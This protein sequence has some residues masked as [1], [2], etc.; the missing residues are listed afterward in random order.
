[1]RRVFL[2]YR[3]IDTATVSSMLHKSLE[4]PNAFGPQSTF[5]DIR[6][7]QLGADFRPSISR[8]VSQCEFFLAVIGPQWLTVRESDG[9]PRLQQPDDYV[10][11]EI[12]AALER[13]TEILII[14][15]LVDGA[16][17]P[18]ADQLPKSLCD[19]SFRNAM[20]I[21][22]EDF[23][24]D[25]LR[26]VERMQEL[27]EP[28]QARSGANQVPTV[29]AAPVT[30]SA[31][32]KPLP[33]SATAGVPA[34]PKPAATTSKPPAIVSKPAATPSKSPAKAKPPAAKSP[35]AS[36]AATVPPAAP[37]PAAKPVKAAPTPTPPKSAAQAPVATPKS[38]APPLSEEVIPLVLAQPSPPANGVRMP[39][40]RITIQLPKNV[41]MAFAWCAPEA[42]RMGSPMSEAGRRD[43]EFQHEVRLTKGFFIGI[44]PVTQAQWEA[45]AGKNPSLFKGASLPVEQVGWTDAV[46]FCSLAKQKAG[47]SLRL[48]TEA[49]W[50]YAA[51]G[52]TT[53]PFYWGVTLDGTQ[54]N[55]GQPPYGT[56]TVGPHL[57]KT[58][59]VGS[60]ATS[61]PH[62]WG[63]CDMHGNVW[64]WCADWFDEKF[65]RRSPKDDPI[66]ADGEKKRRVLRG[67]SWLRAAARCRAACRHGLAPTQRTRHVGFRV[68]LSQ[69]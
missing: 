56:S 14:P 26:L 69:V 9:T 23:D 43:N 38:A 1:M 31:P 40:H 32:V 25:V 15:L 33:K 5:I 47:H 3:R 2:S 20:R 55:C 64:E 63:L 34:T 49:E 68:V 11:L 36:K 66:C 58:S 45:V 12:E 59:P 19:L 46:N 7:L 52:G 8:A 10:R 41:P 30:A 29:N 51:R 42:F 22:A 16:A 13:K 62:P 54:A 65:Y 67:G 17:M 24:A 57:Q 18:R 27:A 4:S 60:F 35:L 6:S 44:H 37:T 39:G 61:H 53:T 48:P 21:R 50:E 28:I